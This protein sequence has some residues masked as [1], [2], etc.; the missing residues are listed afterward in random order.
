MCW[1]ALTELPMLRRIRRILTVRAASSGFIR[2]AR[3][4]LKVYGREEGTGP[5]D[6]L[7]VLAGCWRAGSRLLS[8]WGAAAAPLFYIPEK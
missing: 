2:G 8:S 1:C 6:N 7:E 4:S 5:S 3:S